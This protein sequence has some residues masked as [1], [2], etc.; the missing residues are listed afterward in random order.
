MSVSLEL[1]DIDLSGTIPSTLWFF[2]NLGTSWVHDA[3][4]LLQK[5][6]C[7]DNLVVLLLS[8]EIINLEST[9]GVSGTLPAAIG[10]LTKLG[11]NIL[12][13]SVHM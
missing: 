8:S 5:A 12:G 11:K 13:S 1:S 10:L 3:S 2:P 6:C 4:V 9:F 7:T